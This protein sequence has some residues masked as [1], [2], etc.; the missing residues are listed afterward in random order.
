[1]PMNRKLYSEDWEAKSNYIRFERA[2]GRCEVCGAKHGDR[3][4][5][6]YIDPANYV[7]VGDGDYFYYTPDG[8]GWRD[9]PLGFEDTGENEITV[10]LT[11]HH[12]GAPKPD[13]TPGDPHDKMDN[14]DENLAALCQRCHLLAD[15]PS[16]I[17]ARHQTWL[18][19]K[20]GS[21]LD[22]G[23]LVMFEGEAP[24]RD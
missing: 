6:S 4:I 2:G 21:Q 9:L 23:Q 17:A 13:G 16:H 7:I 19:K 24:G 11:T 22:A 18:R 5:R 8:E 3:I 12:I 10:I 15:L 1:M 14:R 20:H